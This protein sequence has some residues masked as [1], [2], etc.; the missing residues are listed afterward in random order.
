MR[1]FR[2]PTWNLYSFSMP[3]ELLFLTTRTHS[4]ETLK[5]SS[6]AT[7]GLLG[8][9]WESA[10]KRRR[11]IDRGGAR[12]R[13]ALLCGL[14]R[15]GPT[16]RA[17]AL[18]LSAPKQR[19]HDQGPRARPGARG[20][21][22]LRGGGAFAARPCLRSPRSLTPPPRKKTL[23]ITTKNRSA[24]KCGSTSPSRA[25]SPALATWAACASWSP[26]G[27]TLAALSP[28]RATCLQLALPPFRPQ[29]RHFCMAKS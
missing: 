6:T 12:R 4:V 7:G 9:R 5:P 3:C 24:S 8:Q 19:R 18:L 23:K 26:A 14:Q 28:L 22:S 29:H 21:R 10:R 20:E 27:T 15:V 16:R 11:A 13:A 2:A 1:I 17:R 25:S